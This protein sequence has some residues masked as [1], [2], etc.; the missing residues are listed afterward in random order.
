MFD[1]TK[2]GAGLACHASTLCCLSLTVQGF[3]PQAGVRYKTSGPQR[4]PLNLHDMLV[5]FI[6][7]TNQAICNAHTKGLTAV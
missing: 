6:A 7:A 3:G 4:M 2:H 5:M 1:I